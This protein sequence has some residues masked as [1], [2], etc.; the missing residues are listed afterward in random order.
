MGINF[1]VI[2]QIGAEQGNW[3]LIAIF[4]FFLW[5]ITFILL[6]FRIE[7][8]KRAKITIRNL[9]ETMDGFVNE[10]KHEKEHQ[11]KDKAGE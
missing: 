11:K 2:T 5:L 3:C 1:D 7:W 10:W 8:N 9:M 4:F 6:L